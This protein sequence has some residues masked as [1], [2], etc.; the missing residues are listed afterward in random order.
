MRWFRPPRDPSEALLWHTRVRLS[1]LTLA[2]VATLVV[3]IGAT[4]AVVATALMRESIDRSLDAAITD[5]LTLH[6]LFEEE[7]RWEYSGPL[8]VADT[9]V[10]IVDD[11]GN[12]YGSTTAAVLSDLPDLDALQNASEGD[13]RRSGRYGGREVRLLTTHYGEAQIEF[14]REYGVGLPVEIE[15]EGSD[16]EE[17]EPTTTLYLQA[18]HDLSLQKELE[19][20]LL[21]AI[22]LIALIGLG[23]SVAVTLFVTKRALVPISEAFATERRFVAVASHELRTPVSIIRASA[24]ILDREGLVA[25]AGEPLID[26]IVGETDRMGR[27]VGDL[28]ALAS[29]EAGAI[30]MDRQPLELE[31]YFEDIRRRCASMAE[32]RGIGLE[33]ATRGPLASARVEV[34][35]DRIDQLLLILVDNAIRHSPAGGVVRLGLTVDTPGRTAVVTVSD[36]GPG[37]R[38]DDLERIFEPFERAGGARAD[39]DGAGLGLAIARRLAIGHGGELSVSSQPGHGATFRLQLPLMRNAEGRT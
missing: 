18:G 35:R 6:E 37:I 31:P 34:D 32:A 15:R 20:Q 28:M 11:E 12:V 30:S 13:D 29:T 24:E 39:H 16:S 33:A 27:L 2:T 14:E 17:G 21:V 19:R 7:A 5:P 36:D 1:A 38:D 25:K 9:F 8:G 26:D 10:L 23:G 3:V 22:G 4:T